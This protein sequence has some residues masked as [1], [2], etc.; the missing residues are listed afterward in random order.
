MSMYGKPPQYCSNYSPIKILINLKKEIIVNFLEN[1]RV[2][3]LIIHFSEIN[4]KYKSNFSTLNLLG[5]FN[6]HTKTKKIYKIYRKLSKILSLI[7]NKMEGW[8][9]QFRRIS[10]M[11]ERINKGFW[12]LCCNYR[13]KNYCENEE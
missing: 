3:Y 7:L 2:K 8:C 4:L 11:Q 13:E 9:L 6:L 12:N 1:D 5:R 10:S